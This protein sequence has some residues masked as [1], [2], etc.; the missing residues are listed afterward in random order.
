MLNRSVIRAFLLLLLLVLLLALL[1]QLLQ[2]L[3]QL[4]LAGRRLDEGAVALHVSRDG[5]RLL[6]VQEGGDGNQHEG[7]VDEAAAAAG[8][9]D[10]VGQGGGVGVGAV[11]LL[12]DVLQVL[13]HPRL[14]GRSLEVVVVRG[15]CGGGG[16]RGWG[17]VG[18]AG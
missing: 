8:A 17:S 6:E 16:R 14:L 12:G 1:F 7:E 3:G 11:E 10:V 13:R 2:I 5:A 4:Q 15:S 18:G 9:V